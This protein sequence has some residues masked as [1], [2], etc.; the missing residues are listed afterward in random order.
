MSAILIVGQC[1]FDD[2]RIRRVLAPL[3]AACDSAD[4]ATE[5]LD[6][7]ASGGF[8]LVLVNR[9]IDSTG[10][11]GVDLIRQLCARDGAP[12]VMLVSD[13]PEAQAEA[14]SHGALLGFGK[15]QLRDPAVL[16]MLRP[17]LA[18]TP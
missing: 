1:G 13:Y 14:V 16:D 4:S 15:S 3:G 12:P 10:E 9:I 11:S 6:K 18:H 17:L 8:D 5:T 7:V 2:S